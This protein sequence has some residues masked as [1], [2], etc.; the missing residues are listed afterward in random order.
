MQEF[1]GFTQNI[2]KKI[3]GIISCLAFF[4][5]KSA[6]RDLDIPVTEIIP[7]EIDYLAQRNANS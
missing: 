5:V 4:I 2:V 7:E 6:L 3:D 1:H